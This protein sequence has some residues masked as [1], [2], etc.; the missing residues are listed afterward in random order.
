MGGHSY[1][2]GVGSADSGRSYSTSS[3]KTFTSKSEADPD[4]LVSG[5]RRIFTDAENPII[6]A[7]DVTGS[8]GDSAKIMFDKM[9]MFWGQ[10]EQKGYLSD[11]AVS[12]AAIGDA[13]CDTAPL[14]VTQFERAK[15]IHPW[16]K[17]IWLEGGGGGQTM[18][19]YDLAA[20]FYINRCDISNMKHGF[21][22]FIGDEGFYPE[23]DGKDTVPIFKKLMDIYDTF[24]IHWPYGGGGD[25]ADNRIVKQWRS[26]MGERLLILKDP[27][28]IVDIMLGLVA[29]ATG[30]RSMGDYE[31]DLKG[32]GQTSSRIKT[33][34]DTLKS[35]TKDLVVVPHDKSLSTQTERNLLKNRDPFRRRT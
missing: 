11:P 6:I 18:E 1:D 2:I 29:M 15:A 12:F 22:F 19:S 30:A 25:P 14:Q 28:A 3:H 10:I 20:L 32:R 21:F 27:K 4:V 7:L 34:K 16:L 26:V 13:Y 9:P 8:M 33:V 31:E 24:F 5:E 23:L 17:K 35:F